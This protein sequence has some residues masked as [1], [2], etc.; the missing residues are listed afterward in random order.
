MKILLIVLGVIVGLVILCLFL[1]ITV[2]LSY[3]DKLKFKIKYS[4]ITL[5]NNQKKKK[6]STK[7]KKVK[8]T[9]DNN[10]KSKDSFIKEI[11]KQNGFFGTVKYFS[12]ILGV[13]LKKLLWI[14]RRSKFK[15][16]NLELIVATDDSAKTAIEYGGV[17]CAVYPTMSLLE[18][19]AHFTQKSVN[20]SADFEKKQSE[21][22]VDF[23]VS[24][25]LVYFL[26]AVVSALKTYYKLH[27]KESEKNE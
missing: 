26:I 24:I 11:Y 10:Q 27:Y 14:V 17:C 9:A 15:R 7:K 13:V 22:S 5:F 25:K 16:F 19:N 18:T 21:F 2:K 1:P 6:I 8:E 12:E 4:G 20:V 23:S 3:K